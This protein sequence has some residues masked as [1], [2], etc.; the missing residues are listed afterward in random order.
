LII[1]LRIM[2]SHSPIPSFDLAEDIM[3]EQRKITAMR[4][5]APGGKA[6]V[7]NQERDVESIG[8]SRGR[9]AAGLSDQE[10]IIAE[11]VARDIERLYRDGAPRVEEQNSNDTNKDPK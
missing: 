8:H 6:E 4:R 7:E 3:A 1:L 9:A 2:D 10:Q 5:K 11:I